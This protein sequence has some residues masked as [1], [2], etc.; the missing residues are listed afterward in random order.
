[1]VAG[2]LACQ[3]V[4]WALFLAGEI[5]PGTYWIWVSASLIAFIPPLFAL[6][7]KLTL[8]E[9]KRVA[10]ASF[11]KEKTEPGI[12]RSADGKVIFIAADLE[13]LRQRGCIPPHGRPN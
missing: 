4:M 1:M 2:N 12:R 7:Y 13:G 6:V 3:A 5:G 8:D 11:V 9:A 10:D